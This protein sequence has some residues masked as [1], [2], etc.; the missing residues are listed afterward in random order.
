VSGK[1]CTLLRVVHLRRV[2]LSYK[3]VHGVP[4]AASVPIVYEEYDCYYVPGIRHKFSHSPYELYYKLLDIRVLET[5]Y[6]LS[7]Q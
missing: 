2:V 3:L 5:L 7:N 6:E 1:Y 4:K